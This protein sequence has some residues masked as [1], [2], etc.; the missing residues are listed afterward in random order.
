MTADLAAPRSHRPPQV[1]PV[2]FGPGSLL[3]DLAGDRRSHLV[4]LMPT[5]MQTMHPAIG[6]A[7]ARMPVALTDPWGRL[8][9]SVDSIQ[10]WIYGGEESIREGRR[11]IELHKPVKGRD[12]DGRDHSALRP[13]LWAWVPLSGYPAFLTFCRAFGTPLTPDQERVLY[14]EIRNLARILGVREQHIPPTVE[15]YWAYYDDM[16]TNR[17]VDH[18]HVHAVLD[19]AA[20]P[21]APPGTPRVLRPV[22]R[23]VAPQLG[24]RAVWLTYGTFPPEV[25]DILG[26]RW[27]ARDERLFRLAGQGIRLAARLTPEFLRYPRMPLLAR[28]L[29]RAEAAG[30]PTDTLRAQLEEQIAL[31]HGRHTTSV[32]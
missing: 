14:D 21:Q 28:R 16:V 5:L 31:K 3:W 6:D 27:T 2:P 22:W 20:D 7:L 24:R 8:T 15:A 11:L 12:I 17:L 13:D 9:R 32:A 19:G 23:A 10:L 18:P 30:R 1:E 25:R 26:I 29:A 4:F